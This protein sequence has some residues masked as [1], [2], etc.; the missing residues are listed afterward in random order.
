MVGG[1]FILKLLNMLQAMTVAFVHLL[2]NW[3]GAYQ[4]TQKD[5]VGANCISA[6]S[7]HVTAILHIFW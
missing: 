6:C 3:L 2:S 7:H 1:N 4:D 5:H